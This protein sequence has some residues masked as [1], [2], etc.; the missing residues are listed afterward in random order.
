MYTK[1]ST[2]FD[3]TLFL[4][5]ERMKAYVFQFL[6]QAEEL[7]TYPSNCMENC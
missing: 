5:N 3:P 1:S 6:S 4:F 7:A 2:F